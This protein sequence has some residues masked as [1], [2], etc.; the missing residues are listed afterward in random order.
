[1]PPRRHEIRILF[2]RIVDEIV[3][4]ISRSF[5]YIERLRINQKPVMK[6]WN[7]E[8]TIEISLQNSLSL[9]SLVPFSRPFSLH[10][11]TRNTSGTAYRQSWTTWKSI[12]HRNLRVKFNMPAKRVPQS[13]SQWIFNAIPTRG[14]RD[15]SFVP[16]AYSQLDD[17]R[18]TR[19]SDRYRPLRW[20]PPTRG[21]L[22]PVAAWRLQP[23]R[24]ID[25]TSR[26][27]S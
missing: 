10:R 21:G 8:E 26:H 11:V 13:V 24:K 6:S 1:M 23:R 4:R 27:R 18:A 25:L 15:C 19:N 9:F 2:Y 14:S 5:A 3:T 20:F 7:L 16:S 22:L 17:H 12:S